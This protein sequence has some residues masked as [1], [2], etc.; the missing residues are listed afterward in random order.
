[1]P[2]MPKHLHKEQVKIAGLFNV[3][4]LPGEVNVRFSISANG[5]TGHVDGLSVNNITPNDRIFNRYANIYEE[6]T[7]QHL[8]VNVYP[9][10]YREAT[11]TGGNTLGV[12]AFPILSVI[13]A[14]GNT[15]TS[16]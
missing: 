10:K 3:T 7:C 5:M 9:I 15:P 1:M 16:L 8:E 13:D 2:P 4:T 12:T 14:E 11:I 6:Y